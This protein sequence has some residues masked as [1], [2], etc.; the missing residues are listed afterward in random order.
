METKKINTGSAYH[1]ATG[2]NRYRMEGHFLDWANQ[3]LV[4]KTYPD[5]N[6]VSLPEVSPVRK[7]PVRSLFTPGRLPLR[8]D[9]IDI[10]LLSRILM[11]SYIFTAKSRPPGYEFHY[12]S[13]AS[14]GALY[15]C[16]LY[17]AAHGL[18]G[19]GN[20]IYHYALRNRSLVPLRSS[21]LTDFTGQ[22]CSATGSTSICFYITGIFFRSAWKYRKRAFRY[23]LLDAGHLLE[24]LVLA[25]KSVGLSFSVHYDFNERNLECLLGIDGK[26]EGILACI[27]VHGNQNAPDGNTMAPLSKKR[28]DASRVSDGEIRY[29]EIESFYR[30]SGSLPDRNKKPPKLIESFSKRVDRWMAIE[31]CDPGADDMDYPDAVF[32]RRSKRNYVDRALS[33]NQFMQLIDLVCAAASQDPSP[34]H[35]YA[36]AMVIGFICSN[37]EDIT[38]GFYILDPALRKFGCLFTGDLT[39]KMASACLDQEWLRSAAVHLLF[40]TDLTEIDRAWGPRS[41]R[42]AMLAAGRIGQAIYIGATAQGLGACGIGA[43]YDEET[44][45]ILGLAEDAALLYLMAA[46]PVKNLSK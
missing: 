34:Q 19:L 23:V 31:P 10:G 33:R 3:P 36:S 42:Y 44:R 29:E 28:L 5:P 41:Y 8:D 35:R 24:N 9:E 39:S 21:N 16:E 40:L 46:G 43:L 26:R 37:V 2:Y 17:L 1:R 20:G 7:R 11:Q 38:P 22:T 45:E 25:L 6:A 27:T 15:P 18:E 13:A 4:H 14:A 32:F 12:R 30:A